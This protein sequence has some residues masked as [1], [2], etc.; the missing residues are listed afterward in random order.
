VTAKGRTWDI[1][2]LDRGLR[3]TVLY[4]L[5][6]HSASIAAAAAAASFR[7]VLYIGTSYFDFILPDLHRKGAL[8]RFRSAIAKIRIPHMQN[9]RRKLKLSLTLV[10]TLTDTGGAVLTLMLGYRSLYIANAIAA[11]HHY[12]M[13]ADRLSVACLDLTR[14][15]KGLGRPKLTKWKPVTLV[16]R[17]PN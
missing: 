13:M 4:I 10:L 6:L 16:T 14:E 12:Q 2:C 11:C 9:S 5:A 8:S 3:I 1:D 17:E 7:P 15:R